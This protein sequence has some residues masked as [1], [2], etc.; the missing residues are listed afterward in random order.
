GVDEVFRA[1]FL[2]LWSGAGRLQTRAALGPWLHRAAYRLSRHALQACKDGNRQRC[3]GHSSPAERARGTEVS[4]VDARCGLDH[5]LEP[6][7]EEQRAPLILC[8]LEGKLLDEA[9]QE[10]G[11]SLEEIKRRLERGRKTLASR[12]QKKRI[13]TPSLLTLCLFVP[14]STRSLPPG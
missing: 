12:L 8:Y 10:L 13:D 7:P 2:G 1:T 5:A 11:L 6:L 3:R 9:A 14:D 4:F